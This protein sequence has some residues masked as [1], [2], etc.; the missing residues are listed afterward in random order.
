MSE[1][2][3]KKAE[4][5]KWRQL[6]RHLGIPEFPTTKKKPYPLKTKEYRRG[7]ADKETGELSKEGKDSVTYMGMSR[8]AQY[9]PPGWTEKDRKEGKKLYERDIEDSAFR[10]DK[11]GKIDKEKPRKATEADKFMDRTMQRRMNYEA[12][13]F[14]INTTPNRDVRPLPEASTAFEKEFQG[15]EGYRS[16]KGGT[17]KEMKEGTRQTTTGKKLKPYTNTGAAGETSSYKG[18]KKERN[19]RHVNKG[20]T[21]RIG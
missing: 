2:K 13:G 21:R 9:N 4:E 5:D 14:N 11:E 3:K 12:A 16:D 10:R 18:K 1:D 15:A 20:S 6:A 8:D 7:G 17:F 19:K